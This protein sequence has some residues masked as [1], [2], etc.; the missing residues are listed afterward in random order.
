MVFVRQEAQ[1]LRMDAKPQPEIR[2]TNLANALLQVKA[3]GLRDLLS[4][5]WLDPPDPLALRHAARHLYML[6]ALDAAGELTR[7][8]TTMARLP[9]LLFSD[10]SNQKQTRARLLDFLCFLINLKTEL[11]CS[12]C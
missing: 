12:F 8:G 6:D 10:Q 7:D 3:M 2:R 4:L 5:E 11:E 9:L 1:L